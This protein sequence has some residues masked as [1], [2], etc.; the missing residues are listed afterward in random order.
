LR[1]VDSGGL[2]IC[3]PFPTTG[4]DSVHSEYVVHDSTGNSFASSN[5]TNGFA[6]DVW[7]DLPSLR[8][9]ALIAIA[10]GLVDDDGRTFQKNIDV[11]VNP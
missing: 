6:V 7:Y 5:T 3:F 2:R 8:K 1:A 10:V 4:S 9:V 11:K